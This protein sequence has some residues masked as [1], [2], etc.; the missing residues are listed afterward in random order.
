MRKLLNSEL[1]RLSNEEFKKATKL[2]VIVVLDNIRSQHNVGSVFRTADA[3]RIHSL[4]LCGITATP[5]NPEIHKSALGAENTVDWKYFPDTLSA[6]KDLK[7]MGYILIAVEQVEN[8]TM[9]D[10]LK[11]TINNP[12]AVIFGNEV[13]GI[14]QEIINECHYFIEIPQYGTKHSLNI[15]VSAGIVLWEVFKQFKIHLY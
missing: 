9:L 2:P 1:N 6:V 7:N 13:K 15:A 3:F 11:L 10:N 5:P 14:S 12:L 4:Y 8:S